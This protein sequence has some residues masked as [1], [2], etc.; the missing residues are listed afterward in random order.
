M[1]KSHH[2]DIIGKK[3]PVGALVTFVDEHGKA[4]I[5]KF[6]QKDEIS[7]SS[8]STSERTTLNLDIYELSS[9]E[10]KSF[11]LV[12]KLSGAGANTLLSIRKPLN[13]M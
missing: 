6:K 12:K 4:M 11:R 3:R 1:Q 7:G 8:A 9:A 10:Y 5:L 2:V 13:H